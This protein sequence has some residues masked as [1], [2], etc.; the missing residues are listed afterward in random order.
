LTRST[1]VLRFIVASALNTMA[2][3]LFYLLCLL[4]TPYQVAY[5][6]SYALGIV[7]AYV[8]TSVLFFRPPIAW[9]AFSLFPLVYLAQYLLGLGVLSLLVSSFG[10]SPRIAPLIVVAVTIPVTFALS[11]LVVRARPGPGGPAVV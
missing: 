2:T 10:I 9:K 3:Y 11:R 4:V 5:T 8:L 1:E 7:I 6:L